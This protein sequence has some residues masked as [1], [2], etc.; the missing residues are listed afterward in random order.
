[1]SLTALFVVER[2]NRT[3]GKHDMLFSMFNFLSMARFIGYLSSNKEKTRFNSS[4]FAVFHC[5]I[6]FAGK[7]SAS[8]SASGQDTGLLPFKKR[9]IVDLWYPNSFIYLSCFFLMARLYKEF[10]KMSTSFFAIC[11]LFLF[12]VFNPF[13]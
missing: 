1:M 9:L 5:W 3:M 4:G 8:F 6:V 2:E 11:K 7:I 12:A 10:R 13:I